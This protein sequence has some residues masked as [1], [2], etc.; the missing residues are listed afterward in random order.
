M[1]DPVYK[2]ALTHAREELYELTKESQK[3]ARRA[4][5]LRQTITTLERMCGETP[6]STMKLGEAVR[7]VLM[8]SDRPLSAGGI[9]NALEQIGYDLTRYTNPVAVIHTTVKRSVKK[10]DLSEA[11]PNKFG[12]MTYVCADIPF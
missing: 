6:T 5:K 11:K 1:V 9:K 4:A 12:A 8:A 10:G 3:M 2:E 7:S